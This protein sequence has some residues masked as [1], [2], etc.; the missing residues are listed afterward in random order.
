[1]IEQAVSFSQ[2]QMTNIFKRAGLTVLALM[3]GAALWL[4]CVHLFFRPRLADYWRVDGIPPKARSL[5]ARYPE[6]TRGIAPFKPMVAV[7][8]CALLLIA[9]ILL[10]V[11]SRRTG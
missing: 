1:V 2:M 10:L 9:A 5:A 11:I 3:A 7:S 8:R 6:T 4:P